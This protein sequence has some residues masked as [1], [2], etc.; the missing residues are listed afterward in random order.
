MSDFREVSSNVGCVAKPIADSEASISAAGYLTLTAATAAQFKL[1][2]QVI[3]LVSDNPKRLALRPAQPDEQGKPIRPVPGKSGQ[4]HRRERTPRCVR[5][6]VCSAVR[7]LGLSLKAI[8]GR[9][10]WSIDGGLLVVPLVA[11]GDENGH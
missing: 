10:A 9:R 11:E 3:L 1:A 7:E 6:S 8:A 5:V 4:E 2:E